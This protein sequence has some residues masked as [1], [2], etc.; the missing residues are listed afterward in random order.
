LIAK[1]LRKIHLA[2]PTGT[3]I[4][5]PQLP[6]LSYILAHNTIDG[7]AP[8]IPPL[9]YILKHNTMIGF[10]MVARD[11]LAPSIPPPSYILTHNTMIGFLM[12]AAA[13]IPTNV[14]PAPHGSAIIPIFGL[15]KFGKANLI[16]L[17]HC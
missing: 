5:W 6:P 16:V 2:L 10:L 14:F 8:S 17:V 13:V 1:R 9:S 15:S 12:V 4:D 11:G 3:E 7:L